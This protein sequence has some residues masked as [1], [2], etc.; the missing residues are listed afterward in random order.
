MARASMGR[1]GVGEASCFVTARKLADADVQSRNASLGH[2]CSLPTVAHVFAP[3]A[4]LLTSASAGDAGRDARAAAR[5][6]ARGAGCDCGRAQRHGRGEARRPMDGVEHDSPQP[7]HPQP[8][9]LV[10]VPSIPEQATQASDLAHMHTCAHTPAHYPQLRAPGAAP[11]CPR[12]PPTAP[13]P[14]HRSC[15][16]ARAACWRISCSSRPPRCSCPSC[17]PP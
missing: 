9:R 5:K 6:S 2:V 11:L 13:A 7:Q 10:H 16:G 8:Q 1:A 12:A 14:S 17:R 15:L 3:P 4:S